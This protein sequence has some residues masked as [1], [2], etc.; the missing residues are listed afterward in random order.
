MLDIFGS[1]QT[2]SNFFSKTFVMFP[3]PFSSL[4]VR[5]LRAKMIEVDAGLEIGLSK[6]NLKCF[7]LFTVFNKDRA[8]MADQ[9]FH[10]ILGFECPSFFHC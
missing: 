7:L 2:F 6:I 10:W 1:Y 9:L 5:Y 3:E 8:V 4:K